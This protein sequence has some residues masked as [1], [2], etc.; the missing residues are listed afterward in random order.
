VC[1]CVCVSVCVCVCVWV[2]VWVGG[3][4]GGWV[5][6]PV[7]AVEAL[8]CVC[9]YMPA[10]QFVEFGMFDHVRSHLRPQVRHAPRD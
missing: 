3:W 8:L 6:D 2:G 7:R 9:V 10:T 4:V 5:G 1:V